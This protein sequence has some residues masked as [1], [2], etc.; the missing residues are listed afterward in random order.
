MKQLTWGR[1]INTHGGLGRN[2][3]CDLHNEHSNKLFKEAIAHMGANFTEDATT[4]VA[5]SVTFISHVAN[6]F[7]SQTSIHPDSTAH[8]TR[9]N[10]SDIQKVVKVIT[11]EKLWDIIPTCTH[12]SFKTMSSNP[13]KPLKVDKLKLWISEKIKETSKY[14]RLQEGDVSNSEDSD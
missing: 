2:V 5:R 3:P 10:D 4:R 12:H 6:R 8:T 7:E 14:R 13:L 11:R 1:F 9:S